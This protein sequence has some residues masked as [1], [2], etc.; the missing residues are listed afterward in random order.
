[1]RTLG[2]LLLDSVRLLRS[3]K[4]FWVVL[5]LSGLVALLYALLGF[6]KN[7]VTLFFGLLSFD[8]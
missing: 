5:S 7:G 4:L 2:I 3:Q 6:D 8:H 1:M